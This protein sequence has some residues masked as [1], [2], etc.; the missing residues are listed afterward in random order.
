MIRKDYIQ[1]KR[2]RKRVEL[3]SS[4]TA[5]LVLTLTFAPF[6]MIA[7]MIEGPGVILGD[8]SEYWHIK[9]LK[10]DPNASYRKRLQAIESKRAGAFTSVFDE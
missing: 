1:W 9:I 7:G 4:L 8:L 10:R 2:F 3:L 6:R 5:V